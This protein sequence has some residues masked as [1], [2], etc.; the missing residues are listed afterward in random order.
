MFDNDTNRTYDE[1]LTKNTN[2]Y[3]E[4]S[5]KKLQNVDSYTTL[6]ADDYDGA[7]LDSYI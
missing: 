2:V 3:A 1:I 7:D 5:D 4:L 6:L